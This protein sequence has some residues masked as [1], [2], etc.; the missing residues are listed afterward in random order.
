MCKR[1][2][3]HVVSA[4][5]S[6]FTALGFMLWHQFLESMSGVQT[7]VE[8]FVMV[9]RRHESG[10]QTKKLCGKVPCYWKTILDR[11]NFVLKMNL[12]P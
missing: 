4:L 2:F 6:R 8:I 3:V 11:K 12:D 7:F 10:F 9:Y 5:A 1:W